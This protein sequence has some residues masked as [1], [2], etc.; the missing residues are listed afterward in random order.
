MINYNDGNFPNRLV[1]WEEIAEKEF[2]ISISDDEVWAEARESEEI[3]NFENIY[4]SKLLNGLMEAVKDMFRGITTEGF[5]NC[6]D[7]HLSINETPIHTEKDYHLAVS[8]FE[9]Q[10]VEND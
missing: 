7:S 10:E 3:P 5:I 4:L 6:A 1:V 9:K 2:S 8:L